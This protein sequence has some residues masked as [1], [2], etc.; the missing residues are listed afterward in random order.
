MDHHCTFST[1][2]MYSHYIVAMCGISFSVQYQL[3]FDYCVITII[4]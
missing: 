2:H 3:S 1:K 4:T